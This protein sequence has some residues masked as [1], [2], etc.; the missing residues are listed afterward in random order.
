MTVREP[1]WI[2]IELAHAIH[3]RQLSEH[4]GTP[5]VRDEGLL[6]SALSRP[7]HLFA[8]GGESVDM[9]ELAA[10]YA[11]GIARNHPFVDGNKRTAYVVCRTFLV[12]NGW[13]M[14]S[15]LADRYHV[16]MA[17]AAGEMDEAGFTAWL[18]DNAR[19]NQVNEPAARYGS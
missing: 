15:S 10:A 16:V 2:S 14:A 4:G 19:P 8:Y 11:F 6:E 7:R 13:D 18:K 1:E 3:A 17:L 9:P 5:G 12:L